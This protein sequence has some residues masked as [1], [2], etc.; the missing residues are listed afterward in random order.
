M[1]GFDTRIK[2]IFLFI[3]IYMVIMLGYLFNLQVIK[4]KEYSDKVDKHGKRRLVISPK[5]GEILDRKGRVL[6]R[7]VPKKARIYVEDS[8]GKVIDSVMVN[9]IYPYGSVGGQLLGYTGRDGNGLAGVEYRFD[10]QLAGQPGWVYARKDGGRKGR[11]GRLQDGGVAVVNGSDVHLT[12]DINMQEIVEEELS[13]AVTKFSANWGMAVVTDPHSGEILAM[14]TVPK[15]NPNY[16]WRFRGIDKKSFPIS[17]NYEPGST[18]KVLTL[19]RALESGLYHVG[20]TLDGNSG[21][22]EIYDQVIRDHIPRDTISIEDALSYSSNVCFAKIADSLKQ[23]RMYHLVRDYGF[24]S[25]TGITLPGEERGQVEDLSRWS[26]RTG[27]TIAFGHEISTTLIQ[28]MTAFDAIANGGYLI[29]PRIYSAVTSD[30]NSLV[31]ELKKTVIRSV[32]SPNT[33]LEVRKMM[34]GVVEYGTARHVETYGI[35]LA[36]KTGTSEKIDKETGRY[37][38]S[39]TVA[40][41]IGLAPV[42]KPSLVI[43]VVVDEPEGGKA[44]GQVSAPVVANIFHRI[45]LSPD[46][47]YTNQFFGNRVTSKKNDKKMHKYPSVIGLTRR[48]A[49]A[50]C[51]S[52][53]I[54]FEFVGD[55]AII[56]HQSPDKGD[57]VIGDAPLLLYTNRMEVS[58]ENVVVMPNC[59]GRNMKDAINAL[60]IK[61]ITPV[62]DGYGKVVSQKPTVGTVVGVF[63]PCTLY[64]RSGFDGN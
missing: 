44:G 30:N 64:C 29:K 25:V 35:E 20:D 51:I 15:F 48:E 61:G 22:Y 42:E 24:G 17:K 52:S 9:R 34:R 33:T 49:S 10:E 60:S 53:K 12:I 57:D 2:M 3:M 18:F 11:V 63:E 54:N 62:F 36:G 59:V 16:W 19:S 32:V 27:V 8:L 45:S 13:K 6:A 21:V 26:G 23:Q 37:D 50:L 14:A 7:S 46:L 40:S 58:E 56:V 47:A 31:K 4:G 55:G 38:K 5:R 43:G 28:M 41:F 39:R 1:E